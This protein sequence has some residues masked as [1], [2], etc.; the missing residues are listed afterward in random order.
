MEFKIKDRILHNRGDSYIADEEEIEEVIDQKLIDCNLGTNPLGPSPKISEKCYPIPLEAIMYYPEDYSKFKQAIID[1]W[2]P[3]VDIDKSQIQLDAGSINLLININRLFITPGAKILGFQPQFTSYISS[4]ELEGGKYIKMELD[5]GLNFK[6]DTKKFISKISNQYSL[7]YIDNPNN[8]TG[9]IISIEDL[10]LIVRKAH[11]LDIP[12]IIDEAYGDFMEKSQSGLALFNK[13]KNVIIVRSL[14]KGFGLAG[15]R[16]GYMISHKTI[17][18]NYTKITV[19]FTLSG[20]AQHLGAIA[21]SDEK[22]LA[23]CRNTLS[24]VKK[25]IIDKCSRIK[26]SHTDL[27]VPIMILTHPNPEVD[28]AKKFRKHRIHVTSG[29]HFRNVGKNSVRFR[30]CRPEELPIILDAIEKI[31]KL[32]LDLKL[33]ENKDGL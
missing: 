3:V 23:Y 31:E 2:K 11:T 22:H 1:Y 25:Q 16:V 4:I 15:L 26:V 9:Q 17:G 8:P 10:E 29:E 24:R 20:V 27:H 13:Y 6:F 28:L 12:V 32:P 14:S 7:I 5:P 33:G 18:E 30:V 19:A 21:L